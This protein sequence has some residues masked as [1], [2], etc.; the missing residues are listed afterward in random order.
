M[1]KEI[2][3]KKLSDLKDRYSHQ[4]HQCTDIIKL[5]SGYTPKDFRF[6][7]TIGTRQV[8]SIDI[9]SGEGNFCLGVFMSWHQYYSRKLKEVGDQLKKLE[10]L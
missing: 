2:E 9:G 6:N 10:L 8:V 5:L 7:F 4:V 1:Q 3:L